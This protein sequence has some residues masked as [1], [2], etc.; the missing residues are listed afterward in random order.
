MNVV[1]HLTKNLLYFRNI[2]CIFPHLQEKYQ[3]YQKVNI[4]V[5]GGPP[6]YT[7]FFN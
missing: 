4:C 1:D 5:W 2:T 3:K 6:N 7:T